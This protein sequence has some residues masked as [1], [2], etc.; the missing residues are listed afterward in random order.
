MLIYIHLKFGNK[1]C[2]YL[3]EILLKK[4]V[5]MLKIYKHQYKIAAND[6]GVF[7]CLY[8]TVNQQKT[9]QLSS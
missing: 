6:T 4:F 7:Q 2:K 3:I 5:C 9:L 8:S 1:I